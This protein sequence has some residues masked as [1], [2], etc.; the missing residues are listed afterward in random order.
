[1]EPLEVIALLA[2]SVMIVGGLAVIA[3]R[4]IAA[5]PWRSLKPRLRQIVEVLV[6]VVG[7]AVLLAALWAA[8]R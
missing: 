5:E 8:V 1:M 2:G 7:A 3:R 6:P 4:E